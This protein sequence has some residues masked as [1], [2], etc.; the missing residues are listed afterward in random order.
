MKPLSTGTGLALLA[1]AIVA[2]PLVNRIGTGEQAVHA[3]VPT[4]VGAAIAA[5]SAAQAAPTIVWYG[6]DTVMQSFGSQ[7]WSC[8]TV[9]RAWSDGKVEAMTTRRQLT[10]YNG[11][12]YDT[13][14][15]GD[16]F[17]TTGW[18]VVST[19]NM[20][21]NAAADINF[22]SRVDGEDLAQ[23]LASWGDAPRQDVPPSDCPL[24]LVNP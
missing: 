6:T 2:F 7:A 1:G 17:C 9:W 3:A 10:G 4:A 5:A 16:G 8:S 14:C 15:S 18:R 21:F 24:A 19:S 12:Q 13:W 11:S 22:D 23:V 20:G